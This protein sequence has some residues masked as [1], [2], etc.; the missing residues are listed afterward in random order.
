MVSEHPFQDPFWNS[1]VV[2]GKVEIWEC[3]TLSLSQHLMP[4]T[5]QIFSICGK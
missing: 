1:L 3:K 2:Q 4:M 5:L